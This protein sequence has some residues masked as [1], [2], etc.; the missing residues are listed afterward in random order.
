[1]S[2]P[3]PLEEPA[4][5][6]PHPPRRVAR[7]TDTDPARFDALD[8]WRGL[9][10]VL[11]AID[12]ASYF[13]AKAHPG[14]F[15]GLP[16][17]V[18]QSAAAF[19]TRF[20]THVAAPGFFF[21]MGASVVLLAAARRRDG[22]TGGRIVRHLVSRGILLIV[23]QHVVE[24]PAWLL[25]T[26]GNQIPLV[27]PPGGGTE[28]M[29]HFGVLYGL[30]ASMIVCA[31]LLAA[32]SVVLVILAVGAIVLTQLYTPSADQAGTLFSPLLRLLLI[33]GHTNAWQVFYPLVPWFPL[34]AFGMVF[35]RI[36]RGGRAPLIAQSWLIGIACLVG[37]AVI[38]LLNGFGN[39]HPVD[40]SGWIAFLN[41]TKY[42]PSL[43]FLLLTMGMNL[44][45]L[46]LLSRLR[47]WWRSRSAPLM[48]FGQSAL[49]FYLLHLYV[50]ALAGLGFPDGSSRTVMYAVWLLGLVVLY[51]VCRRYRTFK[52]GR[53]T[54][55]VWRMF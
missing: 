19:L 37:F 1:M 8:Q 50:Y 3:A 22:W 35:A 53:P 51:P 31:L 49:A 39:I 29:L 10:I 26:L 4:L 47:G 14:E 23:L 2:S 38:R 15:W 20:V 17:P 34:A 33:P 52:Q 6:P 12:H 28:V 30:G 9:I 40:G 13:V 27:P 18:Y 45:A 11:M 42:P 41:V 44:I 55:S 21:L 5:A 36:L 43:A 24:N 54:D 7:A 32:P 48:V 46:S 16:L 25:G